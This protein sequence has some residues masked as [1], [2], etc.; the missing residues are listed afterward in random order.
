MPVQFLSESDHERL[1][2]FPEDITQ[3]DLD[4][5]FWLSQDDRQAIMGLL[6]A[7]NRLG[8]ALLLCCLRYLGFFPENQLL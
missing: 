1:N 7:H 2:R 6:G 8:L 3:E 5:F 4:R